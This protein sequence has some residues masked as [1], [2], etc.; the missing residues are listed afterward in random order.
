M[1]L[2]ALQQFP[3]VKLCN[4]SNFKVTRAVRFMFLYDLSKITRPLAA[5]KSFR[6]AYLSII[7][8]SSNAMPQT[9]HFASSCSESLNLKFSRWYRGILCY[10][11]WSMGYVVSFACH[12]CCQGSLTRQ[13]HWFWCRSR[14]KQV[15]ETEMLKM[16]KRKFLKGTPHL[17][18][19][20]VDIFQN[21][22]ERQIY[23]WWL[24]A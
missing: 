15:K 3:F 16:V 23:H 22:K 24:M 9:R 20:Y 10:R 6:F 7:L 4:P 13:T 12:I 19:I 2:G 5:V 14:S 18:S 17:I 11:G 8:P 21:G 1:A